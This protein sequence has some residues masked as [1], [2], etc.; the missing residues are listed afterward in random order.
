ML[1]RAHTVV[2]WIML[3][4]L[5]FTKVLKPKFHF[6]SLKLRLAEAYYRKTEKKAAYPVLTDHAINGKKWVS[7]SISTNQF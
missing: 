2:I 5:I 7:T 1:V 3:L 4:S 6:Y